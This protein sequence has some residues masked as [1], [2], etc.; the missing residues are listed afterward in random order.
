MR[1]EPGEKI[2]ALAHAVI[3][4]A[5]EVHRVLGPGYLE[6]VYEEALAVELE[7]RGIRFE[8]QKGMSV[9]YKG[10][11]VGE[12]RL[13]LL[14]DGCLLVELK[15]VESFAPIHSAQ[16]MSYLKAMQLPLGLLINFNV[17]LLKNGI[18]RIILA[19]VLGDLGVLAVQSGGAK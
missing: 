3:G 19:D 5:I 11:A 4:A 13:D 12:G 10:H 6:S 14:V 8:R 18:K 2:D 9:D 15:T 16:V 7:L 17:P 1:K